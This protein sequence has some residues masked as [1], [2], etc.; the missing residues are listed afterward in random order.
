MEFL[1]MYSPYGSY[2]MHAAQCVYLRWRG[3]G[4]RSIPRIPRKLAAACAQA[5]S[6]V[7]DRAGVSHTVRRRCHTGTTPP[8]QY[9]WMDCGC[10]G[11]Y[12][13]LR[14]CILAAPATNT[15][16][17]PADELEWLI[18]STQH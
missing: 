5:D 17:L 6:Y 9:V 1:Y 12:A 14:H 16:S 4:D 10:V 2:S 15:A 11:A 7:G 18:G 8:L 13:R 3:A